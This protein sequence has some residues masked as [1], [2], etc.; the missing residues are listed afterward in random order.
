MKKTPTQLPTKN[1][2]PPRKAGKPNNARG[3]MRRFEDDPEDVPIQLTLQQKFLAGLVL[4]V[5]FIAVVFLFLQSNKPVS[6]EDLTAALN[7]SISSTGFTPP[8]SPLPG[9]ELGISLVI[10]GL[11]DYIPQRSGEQ[12][13]FVIANQRFKSVFV[14]R[15]DGVILQRFIGTNSKDKSQTSDLSNWESIA[16]GGAPYCGPAG[17]EGIQV[18]P[19]QR[20]DA[21]FIFDRKVRGSTRV[22]EGKSWDV[23]G[24]YRLMVQ[25]Y[26][27]C[28]ENS[29]FA[30][31]CID[32]RYGES[33][34]FKIV[35]P[36]ARFIT[37]APFTP[38][39]GGPPTARPTG[40]P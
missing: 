13:N 14:S 32:K 37:P 39:P 7:Q 29:M 17:A 9:S 20:A 8:P 26:L 21:S 19:G 2:V 5:L 22:Y 28:P 25:F 1:A 34:Y 38:T 15:C 12:I 40:T 6:K 10:L 16:P 31:D 3:K 36:D 35:E 33:D 4:F 30:T 23:P 11:R 24:T 27:N 18:P